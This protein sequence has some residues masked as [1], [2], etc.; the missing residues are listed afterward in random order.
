MSDKTLLNKLGVDPEQVVEQRKLAV[1]KTHA[2]VFEA[3]GKVIDRTL[4]FCK[5]K[6]F[7]NA[8]KL[9]VMQGATE[10][11]LF[12][13]ALAI[14]YG[15]DVAKHKTDSVPFESL[16]FAA[17]Y[18]AL[19]TDMSEGKPKEFVGHEMEVA[20]K[21]FERLRGKSFRDCFLASCKCSGHRERRKR[22][23][24]KFNPDSMDGW[25]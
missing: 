3:V 24:I 12:A 19:S 23:G 15:P 25:I 13:M 16:I 6:G 2:A 21:M 20:H 10:P 7:G 5:D 18:T 4:D 14:S 1:H 17:L 22:H 9:H 11:G 8:S